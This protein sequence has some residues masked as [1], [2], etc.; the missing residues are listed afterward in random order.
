MKQRNLLFRSARWWRSEGVEIKNG[1][2]LSVGDLERYNPF[3]YYPPFKEEDMTALHLQFAR[4]DSDDPTAIVNFSR[5]YGLL[6]GCEKKWLSHTKRAL[7]EA[8]PRVTELTAALGQS[9]RP[10]R[11]DEL[12]SEIAEASEGLRGRPS[13]QYYPRAMSLEDF[14]QRQK[15]FRETVKM[16]ETSSQQSSAQDHMPEVVRNRFCFYLSLARPIIRWNN[17]TEKWS[18]W[19]KVASLEVVL[20]M[21]LFLDTSGTGNIR[22]CKKCG[23]L[24]FAKLPSNQFCSRRCQSNAK[25]LDHYHRKKAREAES[26]PKTST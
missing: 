9:R 4:L 26:K 13:S 14:R 22:S 21:M 16:I 25:A 10:T 11:E 15:A 19:W 5:Q 6:G 8:L 1:K 17:A 23:S 3:E 12:L 7:T 2:L 18:V 24:F 20:W